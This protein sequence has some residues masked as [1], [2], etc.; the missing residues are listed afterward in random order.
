MGQAQHQAQQHGLA[1]LPEPPTIDSNSP[2]LDVQIQVLVDLRV[3]SVGAKHGA[4]ATDLHH[5]RRHP[6]GGSCQ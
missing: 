4:Q 5:R 3:H 1:G 6:G 2:L